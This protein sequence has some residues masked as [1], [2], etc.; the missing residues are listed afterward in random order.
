[1]LCN[2]SFSGRAQAVLPTWMFSPVGLT[3]QAGLRLDFMVRQELSL[4]SAIR[5]ADCPN[6]LPNQSWAAL[7]AGLQNSAPLLGEVPGW[8]LWSGGA[9]NYS[10]WLGEI[11]YHALQLGRVTVFTSQSGKATSYGL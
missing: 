7:Q 10:P 2:P 9:S 8:A 3:I 4:C 1:M 6:Y 11:G 5:A